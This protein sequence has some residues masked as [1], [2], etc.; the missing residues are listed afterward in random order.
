MSKLEQCHL[1]VHRI[2]KTK[3]L[4]KNPASVLKADL[5]TVTRWPLTMSLPSP[6]CSRHFY[7]SVLLFLI[8]L[9]QLF[10]FYLVSPFSLS[11]D[12]VPFYFPWAL[13]NELLEGEKKVSQHFSFCF[14]LFIC[15]SFMIFFLLTP[16][17]THAVCSD[18]WLFL[19]MKPVS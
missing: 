4:P 9:N 7:L 12:Q 16:Q 10:G 11:S 5:R 3:N 1:L 2:C 19:Q 13:Q 14:F 15:F 17:D 8:E 18:Y 6:A